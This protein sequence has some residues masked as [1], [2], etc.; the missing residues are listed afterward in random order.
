MFF[1][2]QA[3]QGLG[4]GFTSRV[5]AQVLEVAIK[6]KT[7]LYKSVEVHTSAIAHAGYN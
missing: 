1:R 6:T 2:V 5:Q 7:F 4:P 3:F